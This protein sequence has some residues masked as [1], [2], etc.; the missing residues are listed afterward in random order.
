M[1]DGKVHHFS[2]GGLYNGLIL[3]IDDE[4]RSYWDHISG[5]ALHGTL[6][7]QQ[8]PMWG[9]EQHTVAA[10]REREPNLPMLLARST[11]WTRFM[12]WLTGRWQRRLPPGFRMTM[13][14]SDDRFPEMAIG[15]GIAEGDG[16]F[17]PMS[18]LPHAQ[19]GQTNDALTE[20]WNGRTLHVYIDAQSGIPRADYND[21]SQPPQLFS[22][23][24][25]YSRS[26]PNCSINGDAS[27][28]P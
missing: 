16:R 10:L 5:L 9:I 8:L 22:R 24:Y 26:F 14:R 7:G 21:G 25:G 20:H 2:A 27:S 13:D 18:R 19:L 15:L 1:V 12:T 4:S 17:Y 11:W 3:L 6:A 23:W 28:S